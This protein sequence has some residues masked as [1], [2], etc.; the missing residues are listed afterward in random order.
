MGNRRP[1]PDTAAEPRPEQPSDS[2][3]PTP[4]DAPR[5]LEE[6]KERGLT[7]E[8]ELGVNLKSEGEPSGPMDP[9]VGVRRRAGRFARVAID[10]T[11][12]DQEDSELLR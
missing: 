1:S 4:E 2:G 5:T 6:A 7:I 9:R 11:D 8:R 12:G 3:A 10:V